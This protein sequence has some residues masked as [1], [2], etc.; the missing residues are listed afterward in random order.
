M[1]QTQSFRGFL[2][3]VDAKRI[4]MSLS[5]GK[6]IGGIMRLDPTTNIL[7]SEPFISGDRTSINIPLGKFEFHTHP[8]KCL[9]KK[10]C[11]LGVPSIEDLENIYDRGADGNCYHLVFAHEGLYVVG[12][13]PEYRGIFRQISDVRHPE[14]LFKQISHKIQA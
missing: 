14:Q 8:N 6:E 7:R 4:R 9:S 3:P 1:G 12:L 2:D 10:K 11:A 13:K 5:S